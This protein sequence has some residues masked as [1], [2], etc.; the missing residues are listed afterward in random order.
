MHTAYTMD[1]FTHALS[2]A[3]PSRIWKIIL[4]AVYQTSRGKILISK[5][6]SRL[7]SRLL[8]GRLLWVLKFGLTTIASSRCIQKRRFSEVCQLL[9]TLKEE[10]FYTSITYIQRSRIFTIKIILSSRSTIFLHE[11]IYY[12]CYNFKLLF[13]DWKKCPENWWR[14]TLDIFGKDQRCLSFHLNNF[15]MRRLIRDYEWKILQQH[16]STNF[17]LFK[18]FK[19]KNLLA[20]SFLV[21]RYYSLVY[22][23]IL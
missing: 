20:Y 13:Y 21:Y 5:E 1:A 8:L 12:F 10:I 3:Q 17:W 18:F 7:L 6:K 23:I 22:W 19:P 2:P 9:I 11:F 16:L 15:L 14:Q 4:K